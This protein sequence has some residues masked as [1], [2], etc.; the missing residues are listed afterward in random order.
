VESGIKSRVVATP[1][2]TQACKVLLQEMTVSGDNLYRLLLDSPITQT[3][4]DAVKGSRNRMLHFDANPG[5]LAVSQAGSVLRLRLNTS[6]RSGPTREGI[7]DDSPKQAVL[8]LS[9]VIIDWPV[10]PGRQDVLEMHVLRT[11]PDAAILTVQF[12]STA[13]KYILDVADLR[14]HPTCILNTVQEMRA[15]ETGDSSE[16]TT[17]L[18]AWS[19]AQ[20]EVVYRALSNLPISLSMLRDGF[21][22]LRFFGIPL[23][24]IFQRTLAAQAPGVSPLI[25]ATHDI[26]CSRGQDGIDAADTAKAMGL[27]Y[28]RF[29]VSFSDGHIT[30]M[31]DEDYGYHDDEYGGHHGGHAGPEREPVHVQP[32]WLFLGDYHNVA[33][34]M[35]RLNTH[36][37]YEPMTGV[38]L[39]DAGVMDAAGSR[40]ATGLEYAVGLP[41]VYAPHVLEDYIGEKDMDNEPLSALAPLHWPGNGDCPE[42]R[43]LTPAHARL[44]HI[45]SSGHTCFT[46]EEAAATINRLKQIQLIEQIRT[47]LIVACPFFATP[48]ISDSGEMSLITL[49]LC[50]LVWLG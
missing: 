12:P 37:H 35:P 48:N 41:E 50:G 44:F 1:E 10:D 20:F 17:T 3:I 25:V 24:P 21:E 30:F 5:G 33:A 22:A 2:L 13:E 43:Q 4:Y 47:A 28:V 16:T 46:P 27:P 31:G 15:Q 18:T 29:Q 34:K 32:M 19:H 36:E 49:T 7:N 38:Q 26:I 39:L 8:A 42:D 9:I 14:A 23:Q 6:H 40:L 45:D 11:A